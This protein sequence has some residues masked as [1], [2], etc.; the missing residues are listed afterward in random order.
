MKWVSELRIRLVMSWSVNDPQTET[1]YVI[2]SDLG[3][4]LT[5]RAGLRTG[6]I[7]HHAVREKFVGSVNYDLLVND[8]GS[9]HRGEWV[10]KLCLARE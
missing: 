4:T 2:T 9:E 1:L 7:F 10:T 3:T 6:E 8:P 5:S